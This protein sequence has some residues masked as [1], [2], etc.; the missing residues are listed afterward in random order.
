MARDTL[1]PELQRFWSLVEDAV[2]VRP[3]EPPAEASEEAIAEW[4]KDTLLA[5]LKERTDAMRR[6]FSRGDWV[7]L[8]SPPQRAMAA[9][10][11]AYAYEDTAAALYAAPIP[12]SVAQ[13][14][15][16]LQVYVQALR[17]LLDPMARHAMYGYL[18]CKDDILKAQA[19]DWIPW[20]EF[21]DAR[22]AEVRDTFKLQQAP[23]AA[24]PEPSS[25]GSTEI[26]ETES[27]E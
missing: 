25:S 15:E 8:L 21:C 18:R 20:A 16:L 5:W 12:E 14:E 9:G 7:K 19:V 23:A 11:Y 26:P 10:L 1:S 17:T 3:P 22:G 4:A 2:A 27:V 13:D 24:P 6:A